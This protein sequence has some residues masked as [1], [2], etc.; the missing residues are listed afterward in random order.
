MLR[1]RAEAR[2]RWDRSIDKL[3]LPR[4]VCAAL[5][6][7]NRATL[8]APA[9]SE[10]I[11]LGMFSKRTYSEPVGGSAAAQTTLASPEMFEMRI[12]RN[13]AVD[14]SH[15]SLGLHRLDRV[16]IRAELARICFA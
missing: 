11:D 7:W 14:I 4:Y 6:A 3:Y 10:G 9:G 8:R 5:S 16:A 15:P 13:S 12:T 2:P 1:I